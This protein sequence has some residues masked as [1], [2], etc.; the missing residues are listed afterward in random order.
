MSDSQGGRPTEFKSE[1]VEQAE[2]LCA[3]GATDEEVA[4]FFDVSSR[5][6]Y[7]WKNIYPEFCQALKAGKDAADERVV[8]SL[9]QQAT[10][11][12]YTEKEAI[13]VKD[14]QHVE[15]V[16][17]VEVEKYAPGQPTP[18]IFWLKNRRKDE[19]RDKQDHEHSGKDGS[20]IK[21]VFGWLPNSE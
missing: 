15:R 13:K 3:L 19:W 18:A 14:G 11:Y 10:G 7:R 21:M 2:K 8:R 12:Y 1:F 6:I 16:E 20:A 4:D 5:T 9:Y 17:V